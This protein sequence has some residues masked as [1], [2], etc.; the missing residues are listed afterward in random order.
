[1]FLKS[2]KEIL[3]ETIELKGAEGVAFYIA[4]L[5]NEKYNFE[6]AI[7]YYKKNKNSKEFDSEK[8][9]N[10]CKKQIKALEEKISKEE[11][12]FE[13]KFGKKLNYLIK[14]NLEEIKKME[15]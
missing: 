3:N 11:A 5:Y 9:I 7:K 6:E 8:E 12:E 2:K 13:K 10:D 1:M 15:S 14:K 4:S